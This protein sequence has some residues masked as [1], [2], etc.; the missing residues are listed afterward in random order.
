MLLSVL[1]MMN[2]YS[3]Q[4]GPIEL[5]GIACL[6]H[7]KGIESARNTT[8]EIHKSPA[9]GSW[10]WSKF[11]DRKPVPTRF[12]RTFMLP[13]GIKSG[14]VWVSA[15]VSYRLWIN[16][17]LVSRG[18]A[19]P[20]R[21][22]DSPAPGPWFD[23]L[24]DIHRFL[25]PGKNTIAAEV[26][27]DVLVQNE[28]TTGNPG[29]KLDLVAE[30]KQGDTVTLGTDSSWRQSPAPDLAEHQGPNGFY[31][32]LR[33]EPSG[34]QE[35][36]FDDALWNP[37]IISNTDR[38]PNLL[39]ELPPPMEASV[40]PI[41]V[42]RFS[43]GVHPNGHHGGATFTKAGRY[44]VRFPRVLSARIALTISGHEG[45]KLHVLSS[46]PDADGF[47]R[48]AEIILREGVQ[49]V[50]IPYLNSFSTLNIIA[51]DVT[52]PITIDEV[53]A[54]FVSYPVRYQGSFTCDEANLNR[55]WEVCRWVTQICMQTHYLD[56]PDHQEPICDPGDYLI[57]SLN[58]YYAFGDPWLARQDLRKFARIL[59]QRQFQNFHTSYALLWL[60]MLREYQ[61]YTGDLSLALELAPTAH[62]LLDRFGS[63]IGKNGLISNAP[64]YMFMDWVQIEGFSAHHPPAVIGQGYMSAWYYQALKDDLY[65][66]ELESNI[67]RQARNQELMR[68]LEQSFERELWDPVK[69]LYRDGKP[70]QSDVSPNSWLPADKDIQT[71]STQVN[72][73]AINV[74]LADK[75]RSKQI[76]RNLMARTD[77][78]C[79]PYFMHFVF[80]ALDSANLFDEFAPGQLARWKVHED[81]QSFSE[82]WDHGDRS[83]AWNA[84]PLFQL[85]ARVLGVRPLLP[86]FSQ[87]EISPHVM[88]LKWA[89]GKIPTPHGLIKLAWTRYGTELEIKFKVPKGTSA[90]VGGKLFPAGDHSLTIQITM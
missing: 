37:S 13:S 65:L 75:A 90:K 16:G 39:S 12:R 30:T 54:I 61:L 58:N 23:D 5:S 89:Q 41:G 28:G 55:L 33:K 11:N 81:T 69:G 45:T 68:G 84:T 4:V 77:L 67:A 51:E 46:E 59:H 78:N 86:G 64:N 27:P 3:K 87:F 53:K 52:D 1:L 31:I 22:Y 43:E 34:W 88:N 17:A 56:S 63:Y 50:E 18:P 70:N 62:A 7:S 14:H 47:N 20:G 6:V 83:H 19:D 72:A 29:L 8:F 24:R 85:S 35:T 79:Q 73:L 44:S 66:C 60:Q 38:A 25:R 82:M 36:D 26:M 57:E 21:D 48:K 49:T 32:D 80:Q 9:N 42:V 40:P 74:G 76:I 2:L 15:E 10:I 71:F